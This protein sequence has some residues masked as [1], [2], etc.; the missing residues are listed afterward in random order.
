MDELKCTLCGKEF[1]NK[2]GLGGHQAWLHGVKKPTLGETVRDGLAKLGGRLSVIEGRVKGLEGRPLPMLA[3]PGRVAPVTPEAMAE[4]LLKVL[5]E[6]GTPCVAYD[7]SL[8]CKDRLV[9]RLVD[10]MAT[11]VK[12]FETL[13]RVAH[14]HPNVAHIHTKVAEPARCKGV[15]PSKT[16]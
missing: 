2:A 9:R 13:P 4:A 5:G 15:S 12:H 10:L 14:L 7:S 11:P 3:D 16:P 6:P 8:A 1:K